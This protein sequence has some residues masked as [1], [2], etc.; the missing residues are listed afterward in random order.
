MRLAQVDVADNDQLLH[1]LIDGATDY[2]IFKLDPAGCV[3]NWNPGAQRLLGYAED[4]VIG[5]YFGIFFAPHDRQAGMP[6][7]ELKQALELGRGE[8]ENWL[9]RRDG[10]LLWASG[11]SVPLWDEQHQLR[12]F[13]KIFRDRSERKAL[14]TAREAFLT[15]ASHDLKSPLTTIKGLAQIWQRWA[16]KPGRLDRHRLVKDLQRIDAATTKIV[17][18]LNQLMDVSQLRL[19][20]LLSL[21]CRT[22]DL[23]ALTRQIAA[24]HEYLAGERELQV[25][26]AVAE[27]IGN[28]DAFRLE[29]MLDNLLSNAIKYSPQGGRITVTLTRTADDSGHWAVLTVADQGLGI[30]TEDLPYIFNQFYRAGNVPGRIHG[31]GVGLSG[32]RQIVEQHGGAIS[33]ASQE[34]Q[35]TTF[36]VRLP[37][38]PLAEE[39]RMVDTS[40]ATGTTT[41]RP[42]GRDPASAPS[43]RPTPGQSKRHEQ[44]TIA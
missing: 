4:E 16:A 7:H 28:W 14:E 6:E 24:E 11:H 30:P 18:Q 40:R 15:A 5:E 12:G 38:S 44:A 19:G 29:R 21:E 23:V 33:V 39:P 20:Q 25:N 10:R 36:T 2:A 1:A 13:A 22:L 9:V 35:G 42:S 26:A 8:D 32:V 34:G 37:L 41:G 17:K 43:G 3:A 27:L 31:S